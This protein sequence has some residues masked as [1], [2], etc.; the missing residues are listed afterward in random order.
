MSVLID[1]YMLWLSDE[2]EI[3][4]N[5]PFF[6]SI[7]SLCT[8]PDY[9]KRL[10]IALYKGMIDGILQRQLFPFPIR[11][12]VIKDYDLKKTVLILNQAFSNIILK[13]IESIDIDGCLGQQNFEVEDDNTMKED[14]KYF[15]MLSILLTP[16]Y[17]PNI[18][19][20]DRIITGKK[21]EGKQIGDRYSLKCTCSQKEYIKKFIFV[22]VDS[23][24][25]RKDQL[26]LE[27]KKQRK[28]I[29][30]STNIKASM[31]EHHNHI[32]ADGKSFSYLDD[33]PFK[34]RQVLKC[35]KFLGL[36]EIKFG[37]FYPETRK[38]VGNMVIL[39][40]E[41]Q[42][43]SDILVVKYFSETEFTIITSLYFPKGMG[44][45]IREYFGDDELTYNNVMELIETTG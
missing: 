10:S 13:E 25:S 24:F 23:F 40:V 18:C 26:V 15:E 4:N 19:I 39:K 30:I 14:D 11:S 42:S 44:Q 17:K 9:T 33:L 20:D 29:L 12:D 1:P 37:R 35:L 6:Q 22:C 5:I 43:T 45:K 3:K 38:Q 34:S 2:N 32:R 28:D 27:I 16:C 41:D 8:N 21:K 36:Y 7:I 31:N